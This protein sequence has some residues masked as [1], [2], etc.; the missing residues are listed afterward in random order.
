[1]RFAEYLSDVHGAPRSQRARVLRTF[2]GGVRKSRTHPPGH[3]LLVGSAKAAYECATG[4]DIIGG[5]TTWST[6]SKAIDAICSQLHTECCQA[7]RTRKISFRTRTCDTSRHRG[8]PYNH[9]ARS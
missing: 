3:I 4:E 1:V 8:N 5:V 2:P 9:R 7:F 6:N